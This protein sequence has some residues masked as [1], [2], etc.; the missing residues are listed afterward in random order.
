MKQF[1]GVKLFLPVRGNATRDY[2]SSNIRVSWGRKTNQ[3]INKRD[4]KKCRLVSDGESGL[5]LHV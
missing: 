4:A 3:K 5:T 1:F 2:A